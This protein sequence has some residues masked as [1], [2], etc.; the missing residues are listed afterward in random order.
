MNSID[1]D[2]QLIL[3]TGSDTYLILNRIRID[4]D[5]PLTVIQS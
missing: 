1:L 2:I 4:F 3:G 5:K